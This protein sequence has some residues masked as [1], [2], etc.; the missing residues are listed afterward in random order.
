MKKAKWMVPLI[1]LFVVPMTGQVEHAPTPDQCRAD[2]DVWGIPK[3]SV[4]FQNENEFSRLTNIM[5]RDRSVTAKTLEARVAELG[6]C[7][8]T[9]SSQSGR[10]AQGSRAYVI[11]E[12]ARMANFMQRHG[13]APQFYQEDEQGQR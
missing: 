8:K 11:A 4:L 10:Y 6:Q 2:A 3:W 9:D 13:Y 5:V 1:L 7:E 12:L